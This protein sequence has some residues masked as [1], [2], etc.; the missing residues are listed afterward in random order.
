MRRIGATWFGLAGAAVALLFAAAPVHAVSCGDTISTNTTLDE[1]LT[2]DGSGLIVTG[3][4]TL[5][6]GK[7]TITGTGGG[8]GITIAGDDVTIKGSPKRA[9]ISRFDYGINVPPLGGTTNSSTVFGVTV[10]DNREDGLR[11][12]GDDN[13]IDSV[14]ARHNGNHGISMQGDSNLLRKNRAD[15]QNAEHGIKVDGNDNTIDRNQA[16]E[17]LAAGIK[18]SGAGNMVLKN[19][20]KGNAERGIDVGPG[21]NSDLGGN[22][23]VGNNSP[24][25]NP[26]C[27][28]DGVACL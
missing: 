7:H 2:C 28:I 6:L 5:D 3:G 8:V 20:A 13:T 10:E 16:N 19:K 15:K 1:D 11:L 27:V 23:G 21:N 4:V 12:A 26:Q 9:I 18:V 17:N 24:L 14:V 22:K 25:P